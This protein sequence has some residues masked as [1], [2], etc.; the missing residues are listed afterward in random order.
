MYNVGHS[1]ETL[2]CKNFVACPFELKVFSFV[3][4]EN[5][6]FLKVEKPHLHDITRVGDK[7]FYSI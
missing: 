7:P 1:F 6:T 5:G 4:D 2:C 3:E